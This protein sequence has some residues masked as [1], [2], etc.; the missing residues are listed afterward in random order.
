MRFMFSVPLHPSRFESVV[1]N[2][3]K[4]LFRKNVLF[5]HWCLVS[6]KGFESHGLAF[7]KLLRF[8]G[9]RKLDLEVLVLC[10]L[11]N[12]IERH[13]EVFLARIYEIE[14]P[15]RKSGVQSGL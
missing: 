10:K 5:G 15:I 7:A 8:W 4:K 11:C 13:P 6:L 9:L 3:C 2:R 14:P 1:F 12:L